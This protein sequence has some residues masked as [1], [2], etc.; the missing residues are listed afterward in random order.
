MIVSFVNQSIVKRAVDKKIVS[1]NLINLRQF[2]TDSYGTVDDRPYGGGA[3]MVMKVDVLA[4]AVRS[5]S[6]GRVVYTSPRG[7]TFDQD[8]AR[9]YG[10][11]DHLI[12]L[13][14]HY[15]GIDERASAFIDEEVS[16]GDYVM[17]GG[18]IAVAA[19][20]D[21]TV[22]LLPGVLKKEDATTGESFGEFT[23]DEIQSIIGSDPLLTALIAKGRN[24]VRLLEYPQY[25]RPAEF[26]GKK[27]PEVITSGDPKKIRA[28]QIRESW[29]LTKK[30]RPDLLVVTL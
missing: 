21:A 24:K 13:A 3:G 9:R 1:I 29:E 30:R 5:V 25:T 28:W 8:V 7:K 22:R 19:I 27:V 15:E 11:L 23:V 6:A 26:E 2:A 20:I 12:L 10:S 17:T 14:G 16:I 18:E 4:R